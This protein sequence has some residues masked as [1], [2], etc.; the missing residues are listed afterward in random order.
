MSPS[1]VVR[2][3]GDDGQGEQEE[4]QALRLVASTQMP[5]HRF[6]PAGQA[7]SQGFPSGTQLSRQAFWPAG[8]ET[9]Q[10]VPSQVAVPPVM[11]GQGWQ[12]TPH[13]SGDVLGAHWF[14]QR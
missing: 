13:V 2:P 12:E 7:P 11:V 9:P 10:R 1:Q 14:W 5:L 4:P 3:S 6:L 8:Q